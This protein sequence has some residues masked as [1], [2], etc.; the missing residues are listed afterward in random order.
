MRRLPRITVRPPTVIFAVLLIMLDGSM[1]SILP[2][3]AA[4]CHEIGHLTVM[5]AVGADVREVEIT[6]FG[7]EIRTSSLPCGTLAAVA[8][9][10]AGASANLLSA[11]VMTAIPYSTVETEF[12]A[13]CSV[14][15]A[16]VNML[17]IRTLDGGCILE[18]LLIRLAPVHAYTAV[19][20]VSA[21]TLALLWLTAVYLLLI[22]GGNL[23]LMLF[24]MYLFA[25]LFLARRQN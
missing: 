3:A 14:S 2:F 10:A 12:F 11:A 19:T 5:L 4:L 25:T 1:L 24:C 20:A 17:P 22:C 16:A 9:Y 7:A 13:A 21:V 8:V 15:L 18:A 6:L 23:S